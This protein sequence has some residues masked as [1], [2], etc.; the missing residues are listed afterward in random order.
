MWSLESKR[1]SGLTLRL[2]MVKPGIV[3]VQCWNGNTKDKSGKWKEN[4]E[5]DTAMA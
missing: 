2:G 5:C 3:N 4:L 1:R